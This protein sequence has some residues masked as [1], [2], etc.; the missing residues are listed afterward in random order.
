MADLLISEEPHS[1]HSTDP[2][3]GVLTISNLI[4]DKTHRATA[5]ARHAATSA[6]QRVNPMIS[7]CQ[8]NARLTLSTLSGLAFKERLRRQ[9]MKS[10]E[11]VSSSPI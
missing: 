2:R 1:M 5:L 4:V 8:R 9:Q 10:I 7:S 11:T 3:R 6:G